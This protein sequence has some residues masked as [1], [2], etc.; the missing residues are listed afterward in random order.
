MQPLA[1][2]PGV[3]LTI[4]SRLQRLSATRLISFHDLSVD[5]AAFGKV[6]M[7]TTFV[8][9]D[10]TGRNA[11]IQKVQPRG[12]LTVP[13]MDPGA[14]AGLVD[15]A[16]RLARQTTACDPGLESDVTPCPTTDFNAAGLLYCASYPALA[17]RAEWSLSRASAKGFLSRRQLVFLGSVDAAEPVTARLWHD[18]VQVGQHHITLSSRDRLIA[19]IN[20]QKLA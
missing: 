6:K 9:H 5:G 17:D 10:P 20:T 8:R 2:Q 16:T 12:V 1:A 13:M 7:I 15:E 11:Q 18:T 14:D 4:A 3:V 19:Q